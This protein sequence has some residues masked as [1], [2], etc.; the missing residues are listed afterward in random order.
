MPAFGLGLLVSLAASSGLADDPVSYARDVV[1]FLEEHCIACHD[2]GFETSE[3]AL[4]SP[5]AIKKGGRRGPAIVPGKGSE[6]ALI[7]FMTGKKQP[8]MPPKTSLPLDQ[9]DIIKRWIDEGA[10]VDEV[11]AL[12]AR[13]EQARK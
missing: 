12:A 8:Q 13:R 7:Q 6:S 11:G 3:L 4:H 2:D 9:I 10:K 1:P 5:E